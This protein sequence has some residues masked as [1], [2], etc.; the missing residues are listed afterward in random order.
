MYSAAE[1]V[2]VIDAIVAQN[3]IDSENVHHP[4][5]LVL[6]LV[7]QKMIDEK[8]VSVKRAQ[9]NK[10]NKSAREGISPPIYWNN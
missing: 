7:K 2:H 10:L 5:R 1:A 9:L 6:T 4:K 3:V 8:R